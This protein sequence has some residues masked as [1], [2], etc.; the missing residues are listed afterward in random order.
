MRATRNGLLALA[1]AVAAFT[2]PAQTVA[3]TGGT[4]YPVSGP[5]IK[6]G[7]VVIVNGKI[8]AVGANVA[9][10]AGAKKI[11]ATGKW[12]TPGFINSSTALGLVDVGFGADAN[13]SGSRGQD[14]ISASFQPW[15]GYNP[16]NVLI[17]A[18]RE[19]GVTTVAIWPNGNLVGGQGAMLDLFPGALPD[20]LLRAPIGIT[21]ELEQLRSAGVG[22]RGELIGKIQ[23][24][25]AATKQYMANK[26]AYNTA[27]MRQ[28]G[29][30]KSDLDAMVPVVTGQLPLVVSVNAAADIQEALR[31]SKQLGFKLVL[32]G[33]SEGWMVAK[34][35]AAAKV[36]VLTGAMNN[37]PRDFV[38]LNS[39]QDN[40]AILHKAGVTV[41]IIGN[42]GGGDEESFNVMN[43]RFEAGNAV[44]YGMNWDDALRAVTLAPAEVFGVAGKIGALKAG[45]EGNVVVWSGD[46]FEFATQAEHV[47]VRGVE[48]TQPSRKDL[49]TQRYK[50][51][52][53]DYFKN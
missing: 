28:L 29:F 9:V 19:G 24:L 23:D 6:N 21:A 3:I 4:V 22:S 10:P 44:G 42:A 35:I 40:A 41:A 25:F 34:E 7:T 5:A 48:Y 31:L 36:P 11:D 50:N 20:V 2:L 17:P 15:L 8:T 18:A 51:L 45:M 38:E 39:R 53:P 14:D 37:I 30:R 52:P 1:C 43:V 46:P 12:V 27:R 49:L 26:E 32:Y 47:L 33:A 16:L 13:E